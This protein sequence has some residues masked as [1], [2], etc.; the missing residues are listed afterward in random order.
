MPR[1]LGPQ[2]VLASL[3]GALVFA[4]SGSDRS[5]EPTRAGQDSPP[6]TI[7][8]TNDVATTTAIIDQPDLETDTNQFPAVTT[9]D[10]SYAEEPTTTAFNP[11]DDPATGDTTLNPANE[12]QLRDLEA[13]PSELTLGR[14][15]PF[16]SLDFFCVPYPPVEEEEVE[17]TVVVQ[18]GDYLSRIA[19]RY[20]VTVD[21]LVRLNN[22]ADPNLLFVGQ[23]LLLRETAST[24][25][26]PQTMGRGITTE[27]ITIVQLRTRSNQVLLE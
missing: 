18:R 20:N 2:F 23:K 7:T 13:L 8:T 10:S 4:C 26:G 11:G 5:S 24:G 21:E 19:D 17:M 9:S 16:Q 14:T 6:S 22:I 25:I 1:R 12:G 3:L 27:G 15:H